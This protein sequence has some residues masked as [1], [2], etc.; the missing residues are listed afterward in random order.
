[1][2]GAGLPVGMITMHGA[3][4]VPRDE[5]ANTSLQAAMLPIDR[6]HAA[7]PEEPVLAVLER[8]QNEDINQMPVISEGQIVGM[9]ARDT[10]LR[11]LQTRLQIGHLAEP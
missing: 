4:L 3:R 5:W 7:S 6:I 9:I 11:M 10:I 1:V 8:L 2:T